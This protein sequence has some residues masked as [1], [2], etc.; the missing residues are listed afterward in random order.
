MSHSQEFSNSFEAASCVMAVRKDLRV[1][2][3]D[4]RDLGGKVH[5]ADRFAAEVLQNGV[6]VLRAV[7]APDEVDRARQT[8]L[9]HVDLMKNTRPTVSSR[10]LAGFHRFPVLE[11]LHHL[12]TGNR[13]ISEAL[14]NLLGPYYRTIGL[15]DITINR[16]Q[17]WHKD[18]LR[19]QFSHHLDHEGPCANNHGKM[20]KVILY[21]QDSS[22]LLVV[23][24]SHRQD[25][26]LE[27]DSFATP[28]EDVP[29]SRVETRAGDAVVID[30]CTTHRGSAEEAFES[31]EVSDSPKILISTVFGRYNCTFGDA[32]ERGNAERLSWWQR[33]SSP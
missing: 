13:Q 8:V 17:Q 28:A 29:V 9:A 6:G 1:P 7:F 19:G 24:G 31:K 4:H 20:F 5:L 30:I 26:S 3:T 25:I 14:T 32:M 33:S 21:T 18:L 23:P 11:P 15:S 2:T 27:S 10:H 12:I 16:S 22:S